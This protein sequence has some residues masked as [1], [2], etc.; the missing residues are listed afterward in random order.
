[1]CAHL[2]AWEGRVFE[3]GSQCS[4]SHPPLPPAHTSHRYLTLRL[5][6][7]NNTCAQDPRRRPTAREFLG[8]PAVESRM[9]FAPAESDEAPVSPQVRDFLS[10]AM[11]MLPPKLA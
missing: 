3:L 9:H 2:Q 4:L 11:C 8:H 1:M 7:P 6:S 5:F 10:S